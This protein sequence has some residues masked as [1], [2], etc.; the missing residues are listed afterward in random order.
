[1]MVLCE[2]KKVIEHNVI[3]FEKKV[4]KGLNERGF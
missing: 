2:E 4:K 3:S 1:M